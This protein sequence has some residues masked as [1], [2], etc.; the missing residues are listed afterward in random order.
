MTVVYKN[1]PRNDLNNLDQC[2]QLNKSTSFIVF[3]SLSECTSGLYIQTSHLSEC[4]AVHPSLREHTVEV[5]L[6][7]QFPVEVN[8]LQKLGQWSSVSHGCFRS[9]KHSHSRLMHISPLQSSTTSH[10]L[11]LH[12]SIGAMWFPWVAPVKGLFWKKSKRVCSILYI[13]VSNVSQHIPPV[14]RNSKN[15]KRTN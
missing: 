4:I 10:C 13:S 15:N 8:T 6:P 2:K 11:E 3:K 7:L 5:D 12:G 14:L 9:W 1:N